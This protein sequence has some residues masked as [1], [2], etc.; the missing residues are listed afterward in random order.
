MPSIVRSSPETIPDVT[1][2]PPSPSGKPT[3]K[4][5]SPSR[6][7]EDRARPSGIR[8]FAATRITA[9]S[10]SGAVPI[11][12]PA[13]G[14]LCRSS[15]KTTVTLV[16]PSITWLFV[17]MIPARS[18][19]TPEPSPSPPPNDF[20]RTLTT[21]GSTRSTTS[22][23]D[24]AADAFGVVSAASGSVTVTT[25]V[26]V[27]ACAVS[28]SPLHPARSSATSASASASALTEAAGT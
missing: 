11:T 24:P 27:V 19:T 22:A 4:T 25:A 15:L 7:D 2:G 10:R 12:V 16:V 1:L 6:S 21:D 23:S 14:C 9:R 18:S 3:A 28:S 17:R 26:D 8:S 5:A 20:V 13:N